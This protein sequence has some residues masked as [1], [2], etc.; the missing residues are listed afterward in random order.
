MTEENLISIGKI[1]EG[2]NCCLWDGVMCDTETGYVIG[3]DLSCSCLRGSNTSLLSLRHLRRLNLG[4]NDF[5]SPLVAS[6][7][8]QFTTLT[9]LSVSKSKFSGIIPSAMFS[10]LNKLV[11][12][13]LSDNYLRFEGNSFE[14]LL[15]N[16][17]Q[18]RE[19]FLYAVN[20]SWVAPTS[21]HNLSSSIMVLSLGDNELHGELPEGIFRFP[22]LQKLRITNPGFLEVNFPKTNWSSPLRLL[23]VL[24]LHCNLK[25]SIPE[26][27]GNLTRLT[28]LDLSYNN[29]IG[30]LSTSF[31]NLKQL[32]Y[33]DLFSNQLHGQ[34]PGAFGNLTKLLYLSLG[35]I[36]LAGNF[37]SGRIPP[38]LFTLPSLL[39]SSLNNNKFTG[40]I[41]QFEQPSAPLE[42]VYLMNNEIHGPI[43]SSVFAL[44]NLTVL[45]LSSNMLT[46]ISEPNNLPKL[47]KLKK[48]DLSNN[49][50]LSFK[51]GSKANYVLALNLY[52]L[53][54]STCNI[55]EFPYF[56]RTLEGLE[57]LHL[58]RNRINGLEAD[59]FSKL[60]NLKWLDLSHNSQLS[61]S[62][63][64]NVSLFLPN[65]RSLSLSFCNIS[66]F[67]DFVRN[68]EGLEALYLSYNRINVIEA[69]TFSKLKNL[70]SLDLSYNSELSL[71]TNLSL[72]LPSLMN[73]QLSSCNATEFPHFLRT[74]EKLS[75]L[76]LS[77]NSIHGKISIGQSEGWPSLTWIDLSNNFLTDIEHYPWKNVQT[78]KLRSNQLGRSLLVPPPSTHHFLISKNR[79][80]GQFPSSICSLNSLE[81]LDLSDNNL[82][83]TFPN[84]LG[85]L[86]H[87]LNILDLHKNNFHGNIP[88]SFVKGNVLQTINLSNNDLDGLLPKS[89]MNCSQLEVLNVGNNKIKDT[90]PHWLGALPELKVFVLR[91][92]SFHGPISNS[93]IG[94]SFPNLR[95]FDLSRNEFS[96][97]LPTCFESF[98]SM[99]NSANVEMRYMGDQG[100]YYHDS[101]V[102]T[103]KGVDIK[104]EIILTF[105]TA[106]D[107]SSNLF[108]GEILEIVGKLSSLQGLNF[109]HNNLMGYIPSTMGNLTELESLDLSSNMLVGQIPTHLA[110][111]RFL[112]VLN[113]S[114][115]QLVGPIPLGNQFNTFLNDSYAGTWDCADFHCQ[116]DVARLRLRHLHFMRK[117]I[118]NPDLNGKR[119]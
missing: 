3:L 36:N 53:D 99:I 24:D 117:L 12:L 111:L 21:F 76:D 91:S 19:L 100:A 96:G 65:L 75:A 4:F 119:H 107:L 31:S 14:N 32:R 46:G 101:V 54:L 102:V 112:E 116:R 22:Y 20:L 85:A 98:K 87:G 48:L 52:F 45:D 80:R 50:L 70:R 30:Q 11:S 44:V 79:L 1:A 58:S 108:D 42:S 10:H 47:N 33:L 94:S 109:S 81:I 90:F 41:D 66:E 38:C 6:E 26:S 25:G 115:N 61:L 72:P 49:I 97:S 86:S 37:L 106:I 63:T 89:L 17:T 8:G 68:L 105:F 15:G 27:F 40:P 77:N 43:P 51:S 16:L 118:L 114:Q 59:M 84:C 18:L 35:V 83:G 39:V 13:D 5:T 71:S 57:E 92:N 60:K 110:G 64:N 82:S 103:M 69:D 56:V 74:L 9:H 29:I 78:L 34:I 113:L 73:R 2:T 95:I 7:L 88:D 104:F 23:E 55:S 28:Y 62:T 93:N 67:A